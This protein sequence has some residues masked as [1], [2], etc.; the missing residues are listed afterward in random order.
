MAD[1]VVLFAPPPKAPE[2]VSSAPEPNPPPP[3]PPPTVGSGPSVG[4]G[5][6]PLASKS[7][8]CCGLI[9]A[10]VIGGGVVGGGG[11]VS[12]GTSVPPR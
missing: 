3:P 12:L 5:N 1:V 10:L 6:V 11:V 8:P 2:L 7:D 4:V 9:V